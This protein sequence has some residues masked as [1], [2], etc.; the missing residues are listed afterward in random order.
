MTQKTWLITGISS[1]LGQALAQTV[2]EHGDRVIGT[3]RQQ[4]QI[5]AFND[6][7]QN[8]AIGI[9]LDLTNSTDILHAFEFVKSNVGKLDVLVN[10]AGL[11]F[12]GAIE[13]TSIEE[14]RAVFEG[15]FFGVLALTKTFLPLLRQQK[16]GH[17][18]QISSHGGFKAFAGFG[19]YNASKFAL[20]GFS[21]ALAQEIAPL[22]IQ[23]TIV[24]PGPFRTNFAGSSLKFAEQTIDDYLA[25]AGAFREKLKS[26]DGVQEGDP[27]KA[28]T[29]IYNL[30]TLDKPPLRLPL[31]KVAVHSLTSKLASV[32]TDLDNYRDVAESVVY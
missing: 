9:E 19:I 3:F 13:E 20:E 7:H 26:V 2:I 16:S 24:E 12:A 5:D 10:N 27:S 31:G 25:T 21:E 14:T 8:K 6:L 23:L 1:G 29:A 18:I 4:A 15:N 30:T 11:G 28:A 17:I 32:Q 22:G